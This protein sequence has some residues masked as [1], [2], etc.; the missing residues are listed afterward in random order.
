MI[1]ISFKRCHVNMNT[2]SVDM[3]LLQVKAIK[4]SHNKTSQ[5]PK[6]GWILWTGTILFCS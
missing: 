2:M 4:L 3:T 1:N 5:I 6:Q